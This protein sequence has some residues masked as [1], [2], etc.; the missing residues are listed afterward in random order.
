VLVRAC[1]VER[2]EV[3]RVEGG[4]HEVHR[5]RLGLNSTSFSSAIAL[6]MSTTSISCRCIPRRTARSVPSAV[7]DPPDV[8]NRR[9]WFR[10]LVST[11]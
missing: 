9:R 8:S 2:V 10:W 6:D 5:T 7:E 11:D 4:G 3:E 1:E